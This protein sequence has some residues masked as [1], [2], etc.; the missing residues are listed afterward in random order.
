VHELAVRSANVSF[1]CR[2]EAFPLIIHSEAKI[3]AIPLP[4]E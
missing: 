1:R 3:G 2:M 4:D